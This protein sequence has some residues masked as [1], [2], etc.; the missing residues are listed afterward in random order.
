MR[1]FFGIGPYRSSADFEMGILSFEI[2]LIVAALVSGW[3]RWW[4][5]ALCVRYTKIF[6]V[7]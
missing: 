2:M 1:C 7:C 3:F 6:F 5:G 4:I